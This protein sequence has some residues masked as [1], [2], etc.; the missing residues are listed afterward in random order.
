MD[1]IYPLER[2]Y[3]DEISK[4]KTYSSAQEFY[5][6]LKHFVATA[7]DLTDEQ[8][9]NIKSHDIEVIEHIQLKYFNNKA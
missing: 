8:K 2:L 6:S 4:G 3:L 5:N 7:D 9:D 1:E